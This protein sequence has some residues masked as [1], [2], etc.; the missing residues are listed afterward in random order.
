[1]ALEAMEGEKH[2]GYTE[3]RREH[4]WRLLQLGMPP[5]PAPSHPFSAQPILAVSETTPNPA[6]EPP[7]ILEETF[8][9]KKTRRG[10][11]AEAKEQT[12]GSTT[13]TMPQVQAKEAPKRGRP[14]KKADISPV[15]ELEATQLPTTKEHLE[16]NEEEAPAPKGRQTRRTGER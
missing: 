2:L 11:K 16:P 1:M 3:S 7:V 6:A 12:A 13:E 10:T 5:T 4:L 8:P 14:R 9:P 15:E